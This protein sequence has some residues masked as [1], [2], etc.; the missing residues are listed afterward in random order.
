[1][2]NSSSPLTSSLTDDIETPAAENTEDY[3]KVDTLIYESAETYIHKLNQ[4]LRYGHVQENERILLDKV[5]DLLGIDHNK[6][7][8]LIIAYLGTLINPRKVTDGGRRW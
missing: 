7:K 5:F 4:D 1:M 6:A 3:M 2:P 8:D